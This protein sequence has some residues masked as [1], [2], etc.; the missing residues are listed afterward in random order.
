MEYWNYLRVKES[1]KEESNIW[2]KQLFVSLYVGEEEKAIIARIIE[3]FVEHKHSFELGNK[4]AIT[5]HQ[6]SSSSV[7][8]MAHSLW[9]M[10]NGRNIKSID[11]SAICDLPKANPSSSPV[12]KDSA[13]SPMKNVVHGSQ[14]ASKEIKIIM[15]KIL[16]E[17]VALKRAFKVL[18]EEI[19]FKGEGDEGEDYVAFITDIPDKDEIE[20]FLRPYTKGVYTLILRGVTAYLHD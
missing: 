8:E 19:Q 6:R 7:G 14:V 3:L 1:S 18:Q 17:A 2:R 20:F 4:S 5:V 13:A 15:K 12:G 10:A 11:P 16:Q 9:P